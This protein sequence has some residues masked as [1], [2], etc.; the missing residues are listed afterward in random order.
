MIERTSVD[1]PLMELEVEDRIVEER[2]SHKETSTRIG[3]S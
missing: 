3:S 2:H 1:E